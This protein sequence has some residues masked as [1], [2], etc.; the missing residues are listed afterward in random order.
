M[1]EANIY[2]T[3]G[4]LPNLK[5]VLNSEIKILNLNYSEMSIFN[6]HHLILNLIWLLFKYIIAYYF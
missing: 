2:N 1:S 6:K 5:V 3:N 4:E